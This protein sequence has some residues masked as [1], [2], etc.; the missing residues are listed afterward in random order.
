MARIELEGMEFYAFHGCYEQEQRV[1][2]RFKVDVYFDYDSSK[3]QLSDNIYDAVS[4][5]DVYEIVAQQMAIKSH[6]LEHVGRRIVDQISERFKEV[7]NLTVKVT[8]LA[9]P[10]GGAL[11]GV[12]ATVK[13]NSTVE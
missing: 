8:K 5:L 7:E 9:P 11:I 10:L 2:N 13:S 4:Y 12:S 6:I 1:G 3:A